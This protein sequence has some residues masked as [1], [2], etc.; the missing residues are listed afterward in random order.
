MLLAI[1]WNVLTMHGPINSKS[2]N[3]TSKW[4]MGFNSAFKG[5]NSFSPHV[6]TKQICSSFQITVM[7]LKVVEKLCCVPQS[8]PWPPD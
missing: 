3:D 1:Y 7:L 5:L 4:Q 2:P 6:E 8:V